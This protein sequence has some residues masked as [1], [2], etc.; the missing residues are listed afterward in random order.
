VGVRGPEQV[1][2]CGKPQY[3]FTSVCGLSPLCSQLSR[4]VSSISVLVGISPVI[5][6]LFPGPCSILYWFSLQSKDKSSRS[7]VDLFMVFHLALS[8]F[9]LKFSYTLFPVFWTLFSSM[10]YV[11][12]QRFLT[13]NNCEYIWKEGICSLYFS[14]N[15]HPWIDD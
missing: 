9:S 6:Q 5:S 7:F 8:N 4:S 10:I 2:K 1:A 3:S 15:V 14:W 12:L 13:D 11:D